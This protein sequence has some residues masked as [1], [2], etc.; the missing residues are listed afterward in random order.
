MNLIVHKKCILFIALATVL[1]FSSLASAHNRPGHGSLRAA[2]ASAT[3]GEKA[4]NKRVPLETQKIPARSLPVL[5]QYLPQFVDIHQAENLT[6]E[7]AYIPVPPT[8]DPSSPFIDPDLR[9][10]LVRTIGAWLGTRYRYGGSSHRGVDCSGFVDAVIRSVLDKEIGSS[11]RT[12]A[13]N[14]TPIQ[15]VDSLQFGDLLFFSGR[16]RRSDKI[17][18]VGIYVGNGVFAHS[19]TGKG[20]IY[21]HISD[22]YYMER[23]RWGGRMIAEHRGIVRSFSPYRSVQ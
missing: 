11:S 18:H 16:N 8:F 6:P 21:T 19:S 3:G 10:K 12:M 5:R 15:D 2:L 13:E 17:G 1:A 22:G 20:V 14:F 23:F 7:D 9:F 4:K